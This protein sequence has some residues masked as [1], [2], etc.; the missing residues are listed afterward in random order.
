MSPTSTALIPL[1]VGEL[2]YVSLAHVLDYV[3][4]HGTYPPGLRE[5]MRQVLRRYERD[6]TNALVERGFPATAVLTY[7][8]NAT[9]KL[10]EWIDQKSARTEAAQEHFNQWLEEWTDG[11]DVS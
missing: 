2:M 8:Q 6:R 4:E 11:E 3:S 5:N 7:T 9:A 1:G 10:N